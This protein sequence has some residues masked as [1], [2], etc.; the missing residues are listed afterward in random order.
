MAG[1][2]DKSVFAKASSIKDALSKKEAKEVAD[3]YKDWAGQIGELA[4]YYDKKPVPSAA[5]QYQYY[6]QLK[7]QVTEWS[8]QVT[9]GVYDKAGKSMNI[10]ADAVVADN[11]KWMSGLGFSDKAIDAAFSNIPQ[12]TVNALLTGSVYGGT[13]SWSLSKAIWGDNQDTLKHVY[14]I[15]AQ[16]VVMQMP[17][18]DI[19]RKLEQY[20]NPSKQFKWNGPEGYPPI[21]GKKVDYNA[22][23]L[24]RTL[25]QHTYQQSVVATAKSNPL[26]EKIRWVSNGSRVCPLCME[27]DGKV[28]PI[29]KVPLDHPNG[30]CVLE[31]VVNWDKLDEL[32]DWVNEPDG[33]YPWWDNK[34][35]AFGYKKGGMPKSS[36][37]SNVKKAEKAASKI[38]DEAAAESEKAKLPSFK[39]I[40]AELA[41]KKKQAQQVVKEFEEKLMSKGKLGE[42]KA[43]LNNIKKFDKLLGNGY[44]VDEALQKMIGG[45]SKYWYQQSLYDDMFQKLTGFEGWASSS[46]SE[47]ETN[48]AIEAYYK[49]TGYQLKKNA[50]GKIKSMDGAKIRNKIVRAFMNG[51]KE[52]LY[53]I[54]IG[55]DVIEEAVE[56][57]TSKYYYGFNPMEAKWYK[58]ALAALDDAKDAY[59]TFSK[60]G[61]LGDIISDKADEIAKKAA[62]DFGEKLVSVDKATKSFDKVFKDD[63]NALKNIKGKFGMSGN[64]MNSFYKAN[65]DDGMKLMLK[66]YWGSNKFETMNKYMR[67]IPLSD[68]EKFQISKMSKSMQED[69]GFDID[70]AIDKMK[71]FIGKSKLDGDI[72][73]FRYIR[74]ADD[75]LASQLSK[76]GNKFVDNAFVSTTKKDWGDGVEFLGKDPAYKLHIIVPKGSGRGV[77]AEHV[78]DTLKNVSNYYGKNAKNEM[79]FTLQAGTKF[80][81]KKISGNEVWLRVIDEGDEIVGEVAKAS[82][83][84]SM[85][86][87]AKKLAEKQAKAAEKLKSFKGAFKQ[88]AYT[89][90]AKKAAKKFANR[91]EA[92][93]FYRKGLD[94]TWEE[95]A[96]DQKFA[97]WKYTENSHP[98]NKVLSG[99]ANGSWDRKDFVGVGKADWH[100]EDNWRTLGTSAFKKKFG[101]DAYGHIDHAK[102]ISDL[103][104]AIDHTVSKQGMHLRRGSDTNGLAGLLEGDLLSFDQAKSLCRKSQ[105]EMQKALVG[106]VF[107]N[108]S[109]MSTGISEDAGFGG[110]VSYS[111]Y[112]PKGTRYIYAEPQSYYGG[113]IG[114]VEKIYK[115][116]QSYSSVKSEAEIILQ[117]GT[118]F[119][120][121][122]VK[123]FGPD[124]H[125]DMEVVAQPDY[126]KTGYEQTIDGG[127][128]VFKH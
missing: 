13:G 90:E 57:F 66:D 31:P 96:E 16:G 84:K 59:K 1:V 24:V 28:F 29:T 89:D 26:I 49:L 116:G 48:A 46:W 109:F 93:K 63:I 76:V 79:E 95:L 101:K 43:Q 91:R 70:E 64:E 41:E 60:T 125:I 78:I 50:A 27:R 75:T 112:A 105:S 18:G 67:G 99:Y 9:S 88:D 92:D 51:D 94:K 82:K 127:A 72:E 15:V 8:K 45:Q 19:A 71:G 68:E 123:K 14:Q 12:S 5:I 6:Q 118:S 104:T 107:D 106:Q 73:V 120:I 20:V 58:N 55:D 115:A 62:N 11:A 97:V 17:T 86:E 36:I 87:A 119:R 32:A 47:E 126:F 22:Q 34:M 54:G 40:K 7:N 117:R 121:T 108:H 33:T 124:I 56:A 110:N 21:Y 111:I 100:T 30:M 44:D 2:V 53:K 128:T 103:T 122:N 37:I 65:A 85:T 52:T 74:D 25:T 98:M 114:H 102:A 81:V 113:T 4:D 77:D 39:K 23:R 42:G 3:L 83:V 69:F 80:E 35:Q 10:V 61:V 38:A